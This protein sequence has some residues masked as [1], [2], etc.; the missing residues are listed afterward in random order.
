MLNSDTG[1]LNI[2]HKQQEHHRDRDMARAGHWTL[3]ANHFHHST[4]WSLPHNIHFWFPMAKVRY[5]FCFIYYLQPLCG[6]LTGS[7]TIVHNN[8]KNKWHNIEHKGLNSWLHF[9]WSLWPHLPRP[10]VTISTCASV[11]T[12]VS[13]LVGG[14]SG[15][16]SCSG[17]RPAH[18]WL[19][20]LSTISPTQVITSLL[21]LVM[22][23]SWNNGNRDPK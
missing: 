20:T 6:K 22:S 15:G 8:D 4:F 5:I 11:P 9:H 14:P 2:W 3:Y 19:V 21:S 17:H 18:T 13:P 7:R 1:A 10:L 12:L 23:T 16:Q